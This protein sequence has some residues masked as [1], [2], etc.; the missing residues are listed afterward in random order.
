M[1]SLLIKK[2]FAILLG[3]SML[4]VPLFVTAVTVGQP[5]ANTLGQP[6]ANTIG[7]P[8]NSANQLVNPLGVN[9]FPELVQ[10][11]LNAALVIGIPVAVLFIVW[12]GFKF[13]FARGN[14]EGLK[15]ARKN[16]FYT[17]VGVGIFVGASLITGIIVSTLR[18]LGA[19]GF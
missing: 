14:P 12:A 19:T 6:S 2:N 10:K 8:Y 5:T 1:R 4:A 15:D 16:I 11:L 7:Q 18:D 13:I 17:L 3:L 9:S